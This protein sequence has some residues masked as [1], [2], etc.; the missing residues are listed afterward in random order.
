MTPTGIE[1]PTFR[2]VVTAAPI[3]PQY[4]IQTTNFQNVLSATRQY[5]KQAVYTLE[6]HNLS[7]SSV[8]C[9]SENL[10]TDYSLT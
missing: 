3:H 6:L 9:E 8:G 4:L 5:R 10:L 7:L 2:F 1:P